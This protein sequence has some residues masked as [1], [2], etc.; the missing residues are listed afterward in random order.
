MN[1]KHIKT[2]LREHGYTLVHS[3]SELSDT[4][5]IWQDADGRQIKL[6]DFTK[7]NALDRASSSMIFGI[8]ATSLA[9]Y[10]SRAASFHLYVRHEP[11]PR[12]HFNP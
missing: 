9:L 7:W 4:P 2:V 6:R 3:I 8:G 10:L 11:V 1:T 5:E 12:S